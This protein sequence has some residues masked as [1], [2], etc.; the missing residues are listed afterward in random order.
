MCSDV[1]RP[2]DIAGISSVQSEDGDDR[3]VDRSGA[4]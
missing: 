3:V 4:A 1:S 2:I